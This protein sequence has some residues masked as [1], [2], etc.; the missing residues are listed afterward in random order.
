MKTRPISLKQFMDNKR[1]STSLISASLLWFIELS[2]YISQVRIEPNGIHDGIM[3]P[4]AV[5][6]SEGLI[7]NRDFFSQYGPITPILQGYWLKVFPVE[8]I[9]LRILD[10]ILLATIGLYLF[11][12]IILGCSLPSL[13]SGNIALVNRFVNFIGPSSYQFS[14]FSRENA[15]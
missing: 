15:I 13:S 5:A 6:S 4:G 14:N 12:F 7:P 2:I 10:A 11:G 9:S 8:I 3:F 1:K